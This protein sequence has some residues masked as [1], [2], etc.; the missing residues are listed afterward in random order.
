MTA[1]LKYIQ[2]G[3]GGHGQSWCTAVHARLRA[4]GLA[5][6]VAAV[7]IDRNVLSTAQ[8]QLGLA[9]N[10]LYD[11]ADEALAA[12]AEVDFI[13]I[14]VPPAAHEQMVDL[15]LRHDCHILSEKPVADTMEASCRIY[16]KV[17]AAGAKMAVTMSHRFDQDKQALERQLKSG[18]HGPLDY[19]IGRNTW[20]FRKVGAWGAKFR[21]EIA[22][23]LLIEGTVHHFDIMRALSGADAKNVHAITWNPPWSEFAGDAQG[24]ILVEMLN[25]VKVFYEGAKANASKLNGWSDDYWRAECRDATLELDQRKLRVVRENR[26]RTEDLP[27][28]EQDAWRNCWI[29]EMFVHWLNGGDPP[30]CTLDDNMQCMAMLFA[31]VE[32]AHTGRIVD[33]QAF[34]HEHMHS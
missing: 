23:P 20:N 12:H 28:E 21:Y 17:R 2:I 22:D 31:A 5:E 6:P 15:A 7:D 10:A 9:E 33:V 19:L 25:G 16:N 13:T 8:E 1:P 27:L 34:L 32:S 14:V 4:L 29:A 30:P 26:D 24:L 3:V 18:R 11:S